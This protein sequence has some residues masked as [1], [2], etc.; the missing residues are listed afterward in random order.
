MEMLAAATG[1]FGK[2]SSLSAYSLHSATPI[3]SPSSSSTNLPS[4]GGAGATSKG[5]TVGLWRVVGATHKTT[6]KDVSVWTF[7]KKVLDGMK[8][9]VKSR[10]WAI[11]QLKKEVRFLLLHLDFY[12]GAYVTGYFLIKT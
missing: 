1:L 12:L 9:A 7:D 5:F 10:E 2:S 11:D 4:L 6:S 8:G 3:G